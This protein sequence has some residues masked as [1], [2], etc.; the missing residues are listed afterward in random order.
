[1]EAAPSKTAPA[2]LGAGNAG[3]RPSVAQC[4]LFSMG[5]CRRDDLGISA[6]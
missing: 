6:M 2:R 1:M 4:R 5:P 3:R